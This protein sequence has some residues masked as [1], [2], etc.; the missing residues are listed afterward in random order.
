MILDLSRA[1]KPI[2]LSVVGFEISL[3]WSAGCVRRCYLGLKL[4]KSSKCLFWQASFNQPQGP[5]PSRYHP[6]ILAVQESVLEAVLT[7]IYKQTNRFTISFLTNQKYTTRLLG[8][9]GTQITDI[10]SNKRTRLTGKFLGYHSY[11]FYQRD[12]FL[13]MTETLK[14]RHL[15]YLPWP[16]PHIQHF[17]P[18][19]T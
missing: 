4:L 9:V 7:V 11:L 6:E 14:G 19:N 8:R 17:A 2:R 1:I 13:A 18:Q 16:C 10:S 5:F 15:K 12:P 3:W